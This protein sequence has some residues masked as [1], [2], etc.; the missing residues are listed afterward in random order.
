MLINLGHEHKTS[1]ILA[2]SSDAVKQD[3]LNA[4][5]TLCF[6]TNTSGDI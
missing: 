3:N 1:L 5:C 4:I 2:V 6:T